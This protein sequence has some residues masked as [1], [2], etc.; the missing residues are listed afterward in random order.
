MNLCKRDQNE[1]S[2]CQSNMM[3]THAAH[4][5]TVGTFKEFGWMNLRIAMAVVMVMIAWKLTR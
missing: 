1:P 2:S 3:M 5:S 4:M